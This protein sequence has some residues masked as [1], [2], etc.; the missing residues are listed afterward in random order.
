[1]RRRRCEERSGRGDD[2]GGGEQAREGP[3]GASQVVRELTGI[4]VRGRAGIRGAWGIGWGLGWSQ[5]VEGV[6]VKNDIISSGHR[7]KVWFKGLCEN[8]MNM[9]TVHS[10][11]GRPIQDFKNVESFSQN[12]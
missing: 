5:N 6:F 2:G 11:R 8:Y 4:R 3:L 10:G 7:N 12:S 9:F 1:L